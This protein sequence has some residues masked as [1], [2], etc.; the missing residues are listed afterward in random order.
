MPHIHSLYQYELE[1]ALTVSRCYASGESAK[2]L[3]RS[4]R[5]G[6]R[7]FIPRNKSNGLSVKNNRRR[8]S[9]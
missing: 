4:R 1:R 3:I 9:E 2:L 8:N 7:H 5:A 6:L